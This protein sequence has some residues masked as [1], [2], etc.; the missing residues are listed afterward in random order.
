MGSCR[1]WD[2][3]GTCRKPKAFWTGQL[4]ARWDA[5]GTAQRALNNFG[6]STAQPMNSREWLSW[7]HSRNLLTLKKERGWVCSAWDCASLCDYMLYDS[8]ICIIHIDVGG[9]AYGVDRSSAEGVVEPRNLWDPFQLGVIKIKD[10][11][12]KRRWLLLITLAFVSTKRAS[13]RFLPLKTK[14]QH[15]EICQGHHEAS[16]GN[17]QALKSQDP[18]K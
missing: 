9:R 16:E 6:V 5:K 8:W 17:S 1:L 2:W 7:P 18:N 12:W 10:C 4:E 14:S 3:Y 11:S 13:G 15:S